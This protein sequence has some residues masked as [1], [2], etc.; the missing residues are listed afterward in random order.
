MIRVLLLLGLIIGLSFPCRG[1]IYSYRDQNGHLVLTDAPQN[2]RRVHRKRHQPRTSNKNTR[3]DRNTHSLMSRN[4]E[5]NRLVEKYAVL[6][7]LDERLLYAVIRAESDYD[8]N[9]VSRKGAMGLMQLMPKTGKQYGVRN[10]FDPEE[11]IR[12]GAKHL[13]ALLDRYFGDTKMALAA[14]NAGVTAVDRYNGVPPFKETRKYVSKILAM[15]NG[16]D[17]SGKTVSATSERSTIYRYTDAK[18]RIC[19]TNIYPEN[20]SGVQVVHQ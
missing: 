1:E 15:V 3:K 13:R 10:F 6:Y 11:N 7:D 9:A 17:N 4:H 18:G 19:L 12:A 20:V 16:E 14:Y 5:I 2:G 8:Q